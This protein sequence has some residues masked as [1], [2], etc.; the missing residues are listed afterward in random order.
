MPLQRYFYYNEGKKNI[1]FG[2]YCEKKKALNVRAV[3]KFM[4]DF[5]GFFRVYND[6]N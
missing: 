2:I 6:I 4:E 1:F 5:E 3:V